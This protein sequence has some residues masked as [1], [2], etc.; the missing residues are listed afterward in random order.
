MSET[1]WR[2]YQKHRVNSKN[3][4]IPFLLTFTQWLKVW[5]DSGH[6]NESG[7]HKGQSWLEKV[8]KAH[9]KLGMFE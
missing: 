1:P 2:R 9:T 5:T 6:L 8:T 3:R 4:G 7:R